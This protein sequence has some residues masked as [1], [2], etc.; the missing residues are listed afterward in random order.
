MS[1]QLVLKYI[2]SASVFSYA[3]T[4]CINFGQLERIS[5]NGYEIYIKELLE[6]PALHTDAYHNM[7]LLLF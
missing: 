6:V 2:N 4:N 5:V 1:V 7:L 3:V